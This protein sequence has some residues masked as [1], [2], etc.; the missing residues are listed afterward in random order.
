MSAASESNRYYI[1]GSTGATT[2]PIS[3]W[4]LYHWK[5]RY[6]T[7]A[8]ENEATNECALKPRAR[9]LE[10][11]LG[12]L[13]TPTGGGV[14]ISRTKGQYPAQDYLQTVRSHGFHLEG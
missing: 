14:S 4:L 11:K 9:L 3:S 8:F 5:K 6:A 1:D 13:T 12:L 2:H 7:V 10:Q